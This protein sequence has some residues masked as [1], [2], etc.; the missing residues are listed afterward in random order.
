VIYL[1]EPTSENY[2]LIAEDARNRVYDMMIVAFTKP[3]GSI[4][5]FAGIMGKTKQAHR[6]INV[7]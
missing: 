1:V 6:V 2:K 7:S 4:E 3:I 5:E